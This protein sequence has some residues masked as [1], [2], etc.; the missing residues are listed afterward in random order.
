MSW[1]GGRDADRVKGTLYST[2]G[3]SPC[4]GLTT[5]ARLPFRVHRSHAVARRTVHAGERPCSS[6]TT[7]LP[8]RP[9]YSARVRW[10]RGASQADRASASDSQ[11][12]RP[13]TTTAGAARPIRVTSA[14]GHPPVP[15][16]VR[17]AAD[18]ANPSGSS[19]EGAAAV[20]RRRG[21]KYAPGSRCTR[22]HMRIH[23]VWHISIPPDKAHSAWDRNPMFLRRPPLQVEGVPAELQ[24]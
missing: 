23:V 22:A 8:P 11:P 5:Y 20:P 14:R 7:V 19:K 6:K 2:L 17:R 3:R 18:A 13:S 24:V 1:G 9:S 15:S 16:N 21:D 12:P 4:T 10:A